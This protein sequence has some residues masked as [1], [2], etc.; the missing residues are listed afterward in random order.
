MWSAGACQEVIKW[1]K[2]TILKLLNGSKGKGSNGK[3]GN[4]SQRQLYCQV[5]TAMALA[6]RFG[7]GLKDPDDPVTELE[8]KF[9]SNLQTRNS[10]IMIAEYGP[11]R[12]V[13]NGE[14]KHL[15]R[16]LINDILPVALEF[17]DDRVT[18]VRLTLRKTLLL[19][20]DD[21]AQLPAVKETMQSLEEEVETWESF[22]GIESPMPP[23]SIMQTVKNV[24]ARQANGSASPADDT[25]DTGGTTPKGSKKKGSKRD[26]KKG[27]ENLQEQGNGVRSET[28]ASI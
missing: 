19:M 7:D 6:L 27:T 14:R 1:L 4:F 18:N 3:V 15:L 13:T 26:K 22:D 28:L 9:S 17:K 25:Q 16:L 24:D 11:Y 20:P 12:K 21:V 8:A 10:R 23:P 2:E 5:C